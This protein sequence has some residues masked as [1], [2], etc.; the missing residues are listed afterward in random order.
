M[1]LWGFNQILFT[2]HTTDCKIRPIWYA[3][4]PYVCVVAVVVIYECPGTVF[5]FLFFI[6]LDY[7]EQNG[8]VDFL[9][10]PI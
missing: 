8:C 3:V 2:K 9:Y 7:R 5:S 6:T 1:T 10:T 4:F